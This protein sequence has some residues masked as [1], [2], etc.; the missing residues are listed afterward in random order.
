MTSFIKFNA[1]GTDVMLPNKLFDTVENQNAL[2]LLEMIGDAYF[3]NVYSFDLHLFSD[4]LT[5][6]IDP[7]NLT[8]PTMIK[9]G[10]ISDQLGHNN[11]PRLFWRTANNLPITPEDIQFIIRL[12]IECRSYT[13]YK[14][15]KLSVGLQM[16]K[17][18]CEIFSQYVPLMGMFFSDN[19]YL[20]GLEY[21]KKKNNIDDDSTDAVLGDYWLCMSICRPSSTIDQ[22]GHTNADIDQIIDKNSDLIVTLLKKNNMMSKETETWISQICA[23]HVEILSMVSKEQYQLMKENGMTCILNN[24]KKR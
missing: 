1:R 3:I 19:N 10:N 18:E 22:I 15:K 4:Y 23:D 8:H 17:K 5:G 6:L 16:L 11:M 24:N 20:C 14:N 9:I 2:K 21:I 7:R 13:I 12:I